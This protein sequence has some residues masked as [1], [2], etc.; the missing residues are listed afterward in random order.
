MHSCNSFTI[1][2]LDKEI[3]TIEKIV[4]YNEKSFISFNIIFE[5]E[6]NKRL[7]NRFRK[8]ES[9]KKLKFI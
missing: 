4:F 3:E 2:Y 9:K 6:K 1:L 7:N 8:I 5:K